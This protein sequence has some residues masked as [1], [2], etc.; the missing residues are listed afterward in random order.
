MDDLIIKVPLTAQQTKK[1]LV[2]LRASATAEEDVIINSLANA[3]RAEEMR[4]EILDK[5][6]RVLM[7]IKPKI[8]DPSAI[9]ERHYLIA[10]IGLSSDQVRYVLPEKFNGIL[11]SY[12]DPD[13]VSGSECGKC[14]T[15]KDCVDLIHGKL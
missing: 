10:N 14:Q 12:K 15:V 7:G 1:I 2:L 13:R 8:T 4:N 11:A 9:L 3:L 6:R 5:V